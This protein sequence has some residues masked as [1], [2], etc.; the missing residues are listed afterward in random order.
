MSKLNLIFPVNKMAELKFVTDTVTFPRSE[1]ECIIC[2]E[3]S[4]NIWG[5]PGCMHPVCHTC[6]TKLAHSP[7]PACRADGAWT[8]NVQVNR[9]VGSL[10]VECGYQCGADMAYSDY[11]NHRNKCPQ[12]PVNCANFG[13]KWHGIFPDFPKHLHECIFGFVPCPHCKF[14][15]HRGAHA[16]HTAVCNYRMM[17]CDGCD[18]IMHEWKL[19]LHEC[20]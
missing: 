10:R 13:C 6:C 15:L 8:S 5:K 12:R 16:A 11:A 7:C 17:K 2:R 3:L 20:R 9:L 18:V 14:S 19:P 4:L 1:L